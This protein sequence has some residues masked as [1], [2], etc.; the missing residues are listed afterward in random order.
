MYICDEAYDLYFAS[1]ND[2]SHTMI[3]KGRSEK[4]SS[5]KREQE[6]LENWRCEAAVPVFGHGFKTQ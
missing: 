5:G 4:S 1:G 2:A 3:K 6:T